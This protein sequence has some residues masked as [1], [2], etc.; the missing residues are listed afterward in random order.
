MRGGGRVVEKKIREEWKEE[1]TGWNSE[2]VG[3]EKTLFTIF[4]L[5]L[6]LYLPISHIRCFSS[7]YFSILSFFY[8]LFTS[9]SPSSFLFF[10][11]I[12]VLFIFLS[13]YFFSF[14]FPSRSMSSSEFFGQKP[15]TFDPFTGGITVSIL[16]SMLLY[17]IILHCDILHYMILDF[18]L[19]YCIILY[20]IIS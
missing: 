11:S 9:P 7:L 12:T 18:I 2:G 19:S 6:I 5:F 17:S 16:H 20:H 4:L 3:T 15:T 10:F 14:S 13:L 8:S 1:G